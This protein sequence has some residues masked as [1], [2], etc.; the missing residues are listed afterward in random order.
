ML[1]LVLN[2]LC[3]GMLTSAVQQCAYV[4]IVYSMAMRLDNDAIAELVR[5]NFSQALRAAYAYSNFFPFADDAMQRCRWR[6]RRLIR[7]RGTGVI[8]KIRR[9]A[10]FELRPFL[11]AVSLG[12]H[13]V[14]SVRALRDSADRCE[15]LLGFSLLVTTRAADVF[16]TTVAG[17]PL[18][19]RAQ[20][21][22]ANRFDGA[23]S[24]CAAWRSQTFALP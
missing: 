20:A 18:H 3:A 11:Q 15:V 16:L 8:R 22:V 21:A 19:M 4:F 13:G 23:G 14:P 17:S 1:P 9:H 12:G 2:A 10:P 7:L 24:S 6:Q 5:N